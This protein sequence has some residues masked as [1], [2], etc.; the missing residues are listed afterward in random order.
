MKL[1]PVLVPAA[2]AVVA[3]VTMS[4]CSSSG[5]AKSSTNSSAGQTSVSSSAASTSAATGTGT[6]VTVTESEFSINMP[7]KTLTAGSYTFKVTNNGSFPHNLTVDGPG[8][9]DKASPTLSAGDAGEVTVTLQK[10][11]YEFYCSVDS[12]KDKGMDVK[13]QVT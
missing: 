5:K 6:S 8:V 12:H 3:T 9:E 11:T 2:V 1:T 10:G 7:S 13:V 4:S